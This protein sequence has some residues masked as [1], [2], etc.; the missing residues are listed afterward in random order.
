MGLF[1]EHVLGCDGV[2]CT[3]GAS[4]TAL[5]NAR[6]KARCCYCQ[7]TTLDDDGSVREDR[8]E[9]EH[10]GVPLVAHPGCYGIAR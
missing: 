6:N 7:R 9:F 3:C 1:P 10:G 5:S 4:A 8:V 2:K